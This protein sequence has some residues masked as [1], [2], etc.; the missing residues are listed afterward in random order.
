MHRSTPTTVVAL[1]VGIVI[2]APGCARSEPQQVQ[3][4]APSTAAASQADPA[5][6]LRNGR[7]IDD[8]ILVG[9]QPTPEQLETLRGLGYSTVVNLRMPQE[10]GTTDPGLVRE[11]GMEYVSIPIGGAETVNEANA[12]R[13]AEVLEKAEG[14]VVVHCA[15]GNRV[16]ALFAMKAFYVDGKS[17]EEALAVGRAAGVTRLEPVVKQKLGLEGAAN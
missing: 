2:S 10:S 9:G 13:L 7:L 8:R 12:R 1:F 15:S 4:A 3:T 17:P 6:L 14:G 16:G 5:E 11:L